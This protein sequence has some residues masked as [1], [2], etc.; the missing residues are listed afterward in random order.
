MIEDYKIIT[1]THKSAE[2]KD[3]GH[4][5]L[6]ES[7]DNPVHERLEQLKK[8]LDIPE[9][10]YLA[11]CN[12][13]LFFFRH[14]GAL[15]ATF[16]NRFNNMLYPD[17]DTSNDLFIK[18]EGEEALRHLFEVSSSVDSL[19][20]G[21]HEIIRQLRQAYS[22]CREDKLTDDHIRLA[23]D[24]TVRTAKRVYA[25]TRI[26]EKQV[27]IVSLSIKK[28][29]ESSTS[30]GDRILIVGAGQTNALVCK[31]LKKYQFSNITVFNRSYDK[32]AKLAKLTG[33]KALPLSDLKTYSEGFDCMIVCTSSTEPIINKEIYQQLLQGDKE[34][35]VI[36]DL[37]IPNNVSNDVTT[38]FDIDYIEID[39][40]KILAQKNI[41]FRT[42]EVSKA[43]IIIE[44]E[45]KGYRHLYKERQLEKALHDMPVR[46]K[47][48][49]IKAMNE[50]FA[51]EM[52]GLD[53]AT[54]ELLDRMMTY[55]EKKCI[56]IP[57][58]VAKKT[59][60]P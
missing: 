37:A 22:K 1:I 48:V 8:D 39:N 45:I 26:G 14:S 30:E 9:L 10:L 41:E 54:K 43:R 5:V 13:V 42:R 25:K 11:T 60:L 52:D 51:K 58:K 47:E 2:L 7:K 34:R 59:I 29:M 33:G 4:F 16:L 35:K 27:S 23:M 18:H 50:V 44:K 12:R 46:I 49:K 6:P 55:M 40:L 19:V 36:I 21:E 38:Q 31:F 53:P 3:I 24:A 28:L 32:A 17:W 57:M 15:N 20:V 56:S